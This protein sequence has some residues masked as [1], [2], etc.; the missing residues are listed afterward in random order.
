MKVC[1]GTFDSVPCFSYSMFWCRLVQAESSGL[2]PNSSRIFACTTPFSKH[3][4]STQLLFLWDFRMINASR[5]FTNGIFAVFFYFKKGYY[6]L[7]QTTGYVKTMNVCACHTWIFVSAVCSREFAR[8]AKTCRNFQWTPGH[9]TLEMTLVCT[10]TRT[11]SLSNSAP[12]QAR[13]VKMVK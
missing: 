4:A 10:R 8:G 13:R 5:Y 2:N 12:N 9:E 7:A 11:L 1:A 6:C 3:L